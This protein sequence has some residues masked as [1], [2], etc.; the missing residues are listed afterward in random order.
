MSKTTRKLIQEVEALKGKLQ[1]LE[2]QIQVRTEKHLSRAVIQTLSTAFPSEMLQTSTF[3]K[4]MPFI[5]NTLRNGNGVGIDNI[6]INSSELDFDQITHILRLL[7]Q[8][9]YVQESIWA[10]DGRGGYKEVDKV[11][12][13]LMCQNVELGSEYPYNMLTG[14][15]LEGDDW[16]SDNYQTI[17]TPTDTYVQAYSMAYQNF[18]DCASFEDDYMAV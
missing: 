13:K 18:L 15:D 11:K 2:A 10:W 17:W 4:I 6:A 3:Q 14:D 1:Q 12:F 16:L 5:V 7:E 8:A 9:S